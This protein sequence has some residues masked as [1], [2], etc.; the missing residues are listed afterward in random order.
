MS[1]IFD[2][3]ID[4]L[5][6]DILTMGSLVEQNLR[7]AIATLIDRRAELAPEVLDGDS[8]IDHME[9]EIEREALKVLATHQPVADQ[10]RLIL[11]IM[12]INNELERMG[13]H[14]KNIARAAS[15]LANLPAIPVYKDLEEM[16]NTTIEMVVGSLDALVQK[17]SEAAQAIRDRDDEVDNRY[18]DLVERV[19]AYVQDNSEAAVQGFQVLNGARNLERIADVATNIAKEVQFLVSGEVTL[20]RSEIDAAE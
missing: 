18:D 17:S 9:T 11:A 1:T 5:K 16:S 15:V 13:D 14:A 19:P 2:R 12:K 8:A 10:L 4:R 3:E 6:K 7:R 20:H